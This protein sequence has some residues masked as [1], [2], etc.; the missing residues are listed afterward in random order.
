ME[1]SALSILVVGLT[2]FRR[3]RL[4]MHKY[5]LPV[6]RAPCFREAGCIDPFSVPDLSKTG[7]NGGQ[8]GRHRFTTHAVNLLSNAVKLSLTPY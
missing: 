1:T 5:A 6:V 3:H 7:R 8:A 4:P 2:E